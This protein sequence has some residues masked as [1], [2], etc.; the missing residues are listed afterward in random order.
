MPNITNIPSARVE[1]IDPRTNLISR[2]W[3]RFFFNLFQLTGNGSND[4]TLED[5]QL[6]PVPTDAS[7]EIEALRTELGVGPPTIPPPQSYTNFQAQPSAIVLGPSPYTYINNTGYPADIIVSGGGVS[8]LEFS[9][10][11]ATF[12]STGSFY[13]MFT[14]SP[15]DRLRVTYQTPPQMTLVPR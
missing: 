14:L 1:L 11:G 7:S 12:F 10:N 9:R 15:Y 3:Y 2:E 13:G 4:V 5:L 8:L 6:V